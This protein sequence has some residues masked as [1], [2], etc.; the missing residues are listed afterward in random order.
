MIEAGDFGC[1]GSM[2]KRNPIRYFTVS[3]ALLAALAVAIT[4]GSVWHHH[5][6]SSDKS[7]QIC[8]VG[9]QPIERPL[10]TYRAVALAP[11]GP[12]PELQDAR[13]APAAAVPRVPA[14]APPVA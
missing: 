14:R 11:V 6:G 9:H 13:V 5:V 10:A 8:H 7:C 2:R 3:V 1:P 4:L 12:T